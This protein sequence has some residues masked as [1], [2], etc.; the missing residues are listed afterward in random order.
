MGRGLIFFGGG[1][2]ALNEKSW[3]K[4]TMKTG[5]K[6]FEVHKR[7]LS[8]F[9]CLFAYEYSLFFCSR[10]F[11]VNTS[12]IQLAVLIFMKTPFCSN[13]NVLTLKNLILELLN[14]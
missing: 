14:F 12:A 9:I 2:V 10:C 1:G 5:Y 4:I 11:E 13:E 6:E 3:G 7:F 8:F